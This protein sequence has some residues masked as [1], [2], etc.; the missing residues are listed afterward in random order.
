MP[1]SYVL[2]CSAYT[3][4]AN[5]LGKLSAAPYSAG[6]SRLYIRRQRTARLDMY[7]VCIAGVSLCNKAKLF[8]KLVAFSMGLPIMRAKGRHCSEQCS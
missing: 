6:L 7:R 5:V 8:A 3:V 2:R 1:R 4:V